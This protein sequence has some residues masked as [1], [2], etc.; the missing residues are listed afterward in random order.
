MELKLKVKKYGKSYVLVIP[1][2]IIDSTDIEAGSV[3]T[4]NIR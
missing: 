1:K 2:G 3:L 4:V